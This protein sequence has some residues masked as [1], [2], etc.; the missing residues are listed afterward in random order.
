MIEQV[1]RNIG[2]TQYETKVYIA[3][4]DLGEST[5]GKI[6]AKAN[7]HSG[8]IYEILN[9]LKQKGLVSEITKAGVKHFSPADPS[10]VRE[11]LKDKKKN[12]EQQ[13]TDFNNIIPQ[14]MKKINAVKSP[15]HVEV[16]TGF[17][18]L[19]TAYYKERERYKKGKIVRILGIL[20]FDKYKGLGN[21]YDFFTYN[22]EPA[23]ELPGLDVRKIVEPAAKKD[24]KLLGKYAKIRYLDYNSFMSIN[25]IDDL[26]ILGIF[27]ESPVFI[28]IESKEVAK[29]FNHSFDA[30]WKIAKK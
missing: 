8:K 30:M 10:R 9:S 28:T 18:G 12:L 14:L 13:E 4:L 6:L 3:L 16:F 23:R 22:M 26:S 25:V 1:L 2:L 17:K 21:Y 20:A 5:S 15:V 24:R 27:S 11:Y 7:L 19:K 29:S